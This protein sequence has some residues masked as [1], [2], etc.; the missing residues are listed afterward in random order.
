MCFISDNDA[1]VEMVE[2]GKVLYDRGYV[3]SNDGNISVK[4]S[5]DRIIVTPTGVSKGAMDVA[6]MVVMDLDG[7]VLSQG[8]LG[9]SSEVKMHLRVY[10]EDPSVRAV[11]HAHPIYATSFAVAGIALDKPIMSEAVLQVGTVPVAHY[12]KPGTTDVPDSIAP[13]VREGAAVLLANHG[14]LTWGSS[15]EEALSRMEVVENYA[16]VTSTVMSLGSCRTLSVDQVRGLGELR[17]A[18]GLSNIRLPKGGNKVLN[19]EDVVPDTHSACDPD[20][21]LRRGLIRIDCDYRDR[22][23]ALLDMASRFVECGAAKRTYPDAIIARERVYP[24]GL[25]AQAFDIAISH[26][27]S[28]QVNEDAIG[29]AVLKRPVEFEMMGG[30]SAE[31]LNV[32]VIFMLAIRDPKAQVPTLQKMMA[33]LQNKAL[34]ESVRDATSADE[35]YDLL[36]PALAG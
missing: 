36:N 12:A 27:D 1:R 4:L 5:E 8:K 14:A 6:D 23:E 33:V 2:A 10:R 3:V 17:E 13:Y 21:P 29:V 18:M 20:T 30:M 31:P 24:T 19:A 35:V 32:R 16:H 28:D 9:P 25:P 34:L 26:C 22:T 15:L 11:V 7:R